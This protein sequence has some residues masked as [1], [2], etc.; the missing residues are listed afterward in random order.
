MIL[1]EDYEELLRNQ[2]APP[3]D[4]AYYLKH[5]IMNPTDQLIST[6]F[7][8]DISRLTRYSY[9]PPSKRT[10]LDLTVPCKILLSFIENGLD[11]RTLKDIIRQEVTRTENRSPQIRIILIHLEEE[12]NDQEKV[13]EVDEPVEEE[14]KVE[15]NENKKIDLSK[16]IIPNLSTKDV[17]K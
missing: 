11:I 1:V 9:L 16:M 13:E 2:E 15:V 7:R 3:I 5:N 10:F 12:G 6:L 8:K 14:E 4:Y 17:K